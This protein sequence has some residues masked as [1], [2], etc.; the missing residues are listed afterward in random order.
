MDRSPPARAV[1]TGSIVFG[2]VSVPCRL[3]LATAERAV[4]LREI[5]KA[6]SSPIRHKRVCEAE[7]REV[8][9]EDVGRGYELSD[10]RLVPL[11]TEDL[12]HLPLPTRHQ[13][14]VLGF[15]PVGD[16]DPISYS[17]AYYVGPA[18][19]AAEKPYT[20][21]VTALARSDALAVCRVTIRTRERLAVLRPSHGVLVVQQLLWPDEVRDPGDLAPVAPVTEREME[22]AELLMREMVG[23]DQS[24]LHDQ[25]R[26]ALEQLVDAK[27]AGGQIEDPPQPEPVVDLMAAL[28]ESVR[29]ARRG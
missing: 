21:L 5:H 9:T 3:Y 24:E 10:G 25:Y 18:N 15:V 29:A 17:K 2:L 23:V 7:G 1:W 11:T 20:L 6:D 19:A 22:L 26:E 16:V 28:E 27:V 12:D 14:Q 13:L 8:P 4:R